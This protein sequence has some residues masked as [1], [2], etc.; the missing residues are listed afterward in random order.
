MAGHA[1]R[2]NGQSPRGDRLHW[3]NAALLVR[4][5]RSPVPSPARTIAVAPSSAAK[6]TIVRRVQPIHAPRGSVSSGSEGQR[7][8]APRCHPEGL[9]EAPG[10]AGRFLPEPLVVESRC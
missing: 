6:T 5:F 1:A 2:G 8:A 4:C 7:A 3:S 10:E 9:C